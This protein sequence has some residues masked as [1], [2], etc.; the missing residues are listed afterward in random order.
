LID[1]TQCD[2]ALDGDNDV[3]S[4]RTLHQRH[5]AATRSYQVKI[6]DWNRLQNARRRAGKKAQTAREF[7]Q[8]LGVLELSRRL[9]TS[10]P[11]SPPRSAR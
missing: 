8:Y 11:G 4:L 1:A 2:H 5:E 3:D 10:D 9:R 7:L 6:A